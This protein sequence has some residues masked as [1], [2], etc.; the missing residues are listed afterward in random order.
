MILTYIIK[1]IIITVYNLTNSTWLKNLIVLF[2]PSCVYI[3]FPLRDKLLVYYYYYYLMFL[4][5]LH[6]DTDKFFY[7]FISGED[8]LS[9][10]WN[11][12]WKI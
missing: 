4:I 12:L 11:Y 1:S 3:Y 7:I 6:A 8:I 2:D 5:S 10:I 9:K